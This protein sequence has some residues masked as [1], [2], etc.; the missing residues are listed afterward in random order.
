VINVGAEE[1]RSIKVSP[2]G[3]V[4]D[5]A[6]NEKCAAGTGTLV[7]AMSRALESFCGEM[8]EITLQI[9]PGTLSTNAS[10]HFFGESEVV[11]LIH[12]KN[13]KTGY[14]EGCHERYSGK[15]RFCRSYVGLEKDLVLVG[16]MARNRGFHRLSKKNMIWRS[17]AGGSDY[18]EPWE[19][20]KQPSLDSLCH[21]SI[22]IPAKAGIQCF[23]EFPMNP[24]FPFPRK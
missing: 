1:C 11:S 7:E 15:S 9:H 2:E 4:L 10:A 5:F 19:L 21:P 22:V 24:G 17:R 3:K 20:P 14:R 18:M 23:G 6:I 8:S 13:P 16:G 12:A